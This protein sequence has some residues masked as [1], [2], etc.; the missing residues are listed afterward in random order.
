M[1]INAETLDEIIERMA[2]DCKAESRKKATV[3]SDD[4]NFHTI[5][6]YVRMTEIEKRQTNT[7]E[8]R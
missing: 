2:E 7:E 1:E 3:S 4:E 5:E 6:K 8:E